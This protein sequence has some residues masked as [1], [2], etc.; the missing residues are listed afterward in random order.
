MFNTCLRKGVLDSL[1][2]VFFQVYF[3]LRIETLLR[4]GL[5][6][7]TLW[8]HFEWVISGVVDF[9]KP[10]LKSFSVVNLIPLQHYF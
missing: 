5:F 6:Y 8:T 3:E 7:Y 4:R 10:S 9:V 1:R 2:F